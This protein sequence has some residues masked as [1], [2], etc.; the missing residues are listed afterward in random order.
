MDAEEEPELPVAISEIGGRYLLFDIKAIS[1]LRKNHNICGVFIGTLP[2][3]PSQNVFMGL[4]MQ[5]MPEEAQLLIEHD[6]AYIL[7]DA[8]AHDIALAKTNEPK[9]KQYLAET[10]EQARLISEAKAVEKAYVSKQALKRVKDRK[11]RS[12]D[13][14]P[15]Q[16]EEEPGDIEDES[17]FDVKAGSTRSTRKSSGKGLIMSNITPTTSKSLIDISYSGGE[18][19]DVPVPC[20]HS[21]SHVLHRHL[22]SLPNRTFFTTPGLRFGC[23][24]CVYPGDPLRFHSHFLGVGVDWEEEIDLLDIVG[25]GRLGTGVKKGWLISGEESSRNGTEQGAMRCFSV[26]WAGM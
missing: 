13:D 14:S 6:I 26:E 17:L 8:K 5:I 10:Q 18:V 9:Q 19:D 2:Q 1:W 11:S 20:S 15:Q 23:Q 22:L 16:I 4:P 3:N 25:G 7:E 12:E 24:F 21:A